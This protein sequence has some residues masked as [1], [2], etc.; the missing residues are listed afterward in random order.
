MKHYFLLM[1]STENDPE[2]NVRLIVCGDFNGGDESGAIQFLENGF[3]DESFFEDGEP[4]T[5]SRKCLPL[6]MGLIDSMTSVPDRAPPSTLV[7][8]EL[9]S[10][11]VQGEAYENPTL[12]DQVVERLTAAFYRLANRTSGSTTENEPTIMRVADVERYLVAVNG[13]VGRGS[14]FREAVRQM[15]LSTE[16][17]EDPSGVQQDDGSIWN[18][19]ENENAALPSGGLLTLNGFLNIYQSELVHGKFWGI[20]H[21][22][23]VLGESL[24]NVGVYEARFDRIYHSSALQTRAV[25]DFCSSVPCPNKNEPSDHL[26]VA[27]AFVDA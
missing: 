25:I 6:K 21:D 2:T 17:A 18:D 3:V 1:L 26:P 22:L 4:V 27:A 13:K 19:D 20:A 9:I 24:P 7:V 11:M 8:P 15:E 16:A 12:S 14:E 10:V 5:S 23:T